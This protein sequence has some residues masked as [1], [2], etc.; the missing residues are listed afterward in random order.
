MSQIVVDERVKTF[1]IAECQAGIW[2]AF[3][4][5][6]HRNYRTIT[7]LD[8]VSFSIEPG[9]LAG[10]IGPNGAGKS[11][12]VKIIS[13]ILVPDAGRVEMLGLAP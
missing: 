11:T 6:V 12:T 3:K 1:R 13:E 4:G 5:V 8:H 2:G 9:E 10:Y 7:G